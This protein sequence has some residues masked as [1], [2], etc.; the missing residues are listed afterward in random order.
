MN[1]LLPLRIGHVGPVVGIEARRIL[2]ARLVD[3]EAELLVHGVELE[4]FPGN[5]K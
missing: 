5:G 1:L 4:R 3:I 2:D